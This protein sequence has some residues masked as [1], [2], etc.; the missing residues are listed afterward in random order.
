[1]PVEKQ[2]GN[3]VI[4]ATINKSG[5]FRYTATK[6]GA[7]TALAQ[8]VKLVQEA[9]NS[10]APAQLLAD[11]A[12]QWLV[13]AAIVIGLLTFA[14]WFWVI[15]EPLLFAMTL[16]ITVFVIACPDALGLAT[17]MAVM[18]GTG[19]G[20]MNGILF[21]NAAALE[22][23]TKL[24]VIIFD[25]TGTLTVGQPEVVDVVPAS[26]VP[27]DTVLTTAASVE[28]GS[29]HPLAQA[30]ILR[31][32]GLTV[33]AQSG[34]E[35]IEGMGA[36][37]EIG[38]ERVFLGNRRLMDAQKLAL[39]ELAVEAQRLQGDGRTV[40]HVARAGK[41]IGLIAIADAPRPTA[42]ATVAKLRERGVQVAMLTGD[43]AGT[44]QRIARDLASTL[45]SPMYCRARRPARSRSCRPRARRSGWSA[46]AS[47]TRRH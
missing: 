9:Q 27:V 2:P 37:A 18:V 41:V 42:A 44:A 11:R 7:D 35:N 29:D 22:E 38:G 17:P 10:K 5:T 20:A 21:K 33:P 16:T 14:V 30:I 26:G 3:T 40:V 47:M 32:Q 12:S 8:I 43:N 25:K 24:D 13:L 36:R 15:G 23:A 28:Q 1:M 45:C 31:A 46:T 39:G 19:L 4:G 34:F 6:V